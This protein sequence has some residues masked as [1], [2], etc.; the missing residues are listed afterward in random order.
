MKPFEQA[1]ASLDKI[2]AWNISEYAPVLKAGFADLVKRLEALE[3]AQSKPNDS[4]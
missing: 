4:K 1:V 3:S 2:T